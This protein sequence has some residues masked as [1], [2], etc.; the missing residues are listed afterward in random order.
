MAFAKR[1]ERE[2]LLVN[3][4]IKKS[5]KLV[6]PEDIINLCFVFYH[7]TY[8]IGK[9]STKFRSD[10]G[11]ELL[12]DNKCVKRVEGGNGYEYAVSDMDPVFKGIHCWR[13]KVL[14]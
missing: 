10:Q 6:I 3:G 14:Y 8:I 5:T 9:F 7:L 13:I 12:D 2:I 1:R 4:Y 11:I